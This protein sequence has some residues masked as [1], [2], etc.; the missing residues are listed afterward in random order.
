MSPFHEFLTQI[1]D[2][3]KVVFRSTTAPRDRPTAGAMTV[4]E[5]AFEAHRLDVA[6]PPIEF[7]AAVASAAAEFLRQACWALVTRHEPAAEVEK[8]LRMPRPPLSP[9][10]HLSADLTLRYVPEILER[11]RG[12]DAS[13][14][15]VERLV[16]VMRRWPLSGVLSDIDLPPFGPLE[17]GKHPGLLMLYAERL[18]RTERLAWIPPTSSP[19]W[20]Y[21]E[22]VLEQRRAQAPVVVPPAANQG[23][24][25]PFIAREKP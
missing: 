7:H 12:A 13:D 6:G 24:G 22:L 3:G 8:R 19:A 16:D 11:A 10:E 14:P 5:A 2:E 9:S 15:V 17:F 1:F 18:G 21:H 23:A 25:S 4:L 20:E